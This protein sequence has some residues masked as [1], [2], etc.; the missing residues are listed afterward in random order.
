MIAAL[1]LAFGVAPA[2]ASVVGASRDALAVT[3]KTP[4]YFVP[5]EPFHASLRFEAYEDG[6]TVPVWFLTAAAFAI[7]GKAL[8]DRSAAGEVHLAVGDIVEATIDLSRAID[9]G[10]AF[11]LECTAAGEDPIEVEYLGR[12]PDGLDF[13][14]MEAGQLANYAVLMRTVNGP[15]L[16][17]LWPDVAPN[18]VRNFLDLA[19]SR[20]YDRTLFNRIWRGFMIQGG[21]A[22]ESGT[23]DGP[24]TV[25]AEFSDRRHVR[26]VLSM[27]RADDVNSA[28]YQFFVMQADALPGAG[29]DGQYT[30]FG[31]L[32]SGF[33]TLDAIAAQPGR[34][35][36]RL[37]DG[38]VSPDLRPY[39]KQWI[40]RAVVVLAPKR[41]D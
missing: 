38:S 30:A 22:N 17:E 8:G 1:V 25:D 9:V 31:M 5:G 34:P 3:W 28:S 13:M 19:Y 6:C 2:P 14:K 33:D 20:F 36:V 15:M 26:G 12:A 29:I 39:D 10:A 18:H 32:K 7:D 27:A 37:S 11:W 21:A 16:F 4:T 41:Q 23:G 24:R 35:I 40:E